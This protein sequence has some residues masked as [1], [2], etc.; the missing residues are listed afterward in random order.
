MLHFVIPP[1]W[2][3][4]GDVYRDVA[5][6]FQSDVFHLGGDE[7]IVG[8]D[9]TWAA[10]WNSTSQALV[11]LKKQNPSPLPLTLPANGPDCHWGKA[12]P[13][14]A[15]LEEQG[16]SRSDPESFYRIWA[17]FTTRAAAALK[18]SSPPRPQGEA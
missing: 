16:L 5:G 13:I 8:D 14:L 18:V 12:G 7:V 1:P 4:L 15:A 9:T 6:M 2:E 17:N 10:C 11:P 3:V